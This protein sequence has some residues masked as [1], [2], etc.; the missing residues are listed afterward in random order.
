MYELFLFSLPAHNLLYMITTQRITSYVLFL[1]DKFIK[2]PKHASI[3]EYV[4][5]RVPN[6]FP[7]RIWR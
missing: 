4:L 3:S 2:V 1:K 5:Y 6:A 7:E